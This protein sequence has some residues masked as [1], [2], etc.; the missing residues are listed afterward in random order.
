[1][2]IR[3]CGTIQHSDD[4]ADYY[5]G[6]ERVSDRES[7]GVYQFATFRDPLT[8]L[9]FV[10]KPHSF[11][12][13]KADGEFQVEV[14]PFPF[15]PLKDRLLGA[16]PD[17]PIELY[18]THGSMIEIPAS[19]LL[20]RLRGKVVYVPPSTPASCI[21]AFVLDARAEY[22]SEGEDAEEEADIAEEDRDAAEDE[23]DNRSHFFYKFAKKRGGAPPLPSLPPKFHDAWTSFTTY[24]TTKNPRRFWMHDFTQMVKSEY[25][26]ARLRALDPTTSFDD[27]F[28][29]VVTGAYVTTRDQVK[30]S[31]EGRSR[32]VGSD[33]VQMLAR[34]T[35]F[36]NRL[37]TL[38]SERADSATVYAR[39]CAFVAGRE[40]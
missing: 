8:N 34:I 27:V 11:W 20:E 9:V 39:C 33:G 16:T 21:P 19:C 25:L 22:Q 3:A 38:H 2:S 36:L 30:W 37:G 7:F 18:S 24:S 1:M 14:Q 6:V 23:D 35:T 10:G 32:T 5:P 17:S 40:I 31:T 12:W 13:S 28:F 15:V 26:E 29:A 4:D